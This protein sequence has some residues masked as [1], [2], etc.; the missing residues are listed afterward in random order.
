MSSSSRLFQVVC[1]DDYPGDPAQCKRV[2]FAIST[3]A[4]GTTFALVACLLGSR[5][6]MKTYPEVGLAFIVFCMYTCAIAF[7]TFGGE[8]APAYFIGNL[9]FSTWIGF[10]LAAWLLSQS[11]Q[12]VNMVRKGDEGE[13]EAEPSDKKEEKQEEEVD[14]KDEEAQQA[15]PEAPLEVSDEA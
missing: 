1:D 15:P 6:L 10:A 8:K 4:V 14:K 2:K 11:V 3:G 9:Y 12:K 13:A 7:V 5:G